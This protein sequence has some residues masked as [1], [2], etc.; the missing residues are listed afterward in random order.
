MNIFCTYTWMMSA[1]DSE[2]SAAYQASWSRGRP[3]NR[4]WLNFEDFTTN[5]PPIASARCYHDLKRCT[6]PYAVRPFSVL[7]SQTTKAKSSHLYHDQVFLRVL[8]KLLYQCH[9]HYKILSLILIMMNKN[10]IPGII[11][12]A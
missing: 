12:S 2:I 5:C 6:F 4:D 10:S 8:H 3:R 1:L 9:L 11:N 7:A